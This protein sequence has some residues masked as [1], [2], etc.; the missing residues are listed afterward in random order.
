MKAAWLVTRA[1]DLA[2]RSAYLSRGNGSSELPGFAELA[3]VGLAVHGQGVERRDPV[4][5]S[6]GPGLE[7]PAPH[8]RAPAPRQTGR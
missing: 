4:A 2:Q 7:R 5:D 1:Q 6:V 3:Q 8:S